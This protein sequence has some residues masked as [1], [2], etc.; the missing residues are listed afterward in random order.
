MR[1]LCIFILCTII[2]PSSIRSFNCVQRY[3]AQR[4]YAQRDCAQHYCAQRDCA[5]HFC[6]Q[7]DWAQCGCAQRDCAQHYCARSYCAQHYYVR[8]PL[9]IAGRT[10]IYLHSRCIYIHIFV[11]F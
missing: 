6:A 10:K 9:C 7:R 5:Q 3:R 4:Y 8:I 1:W 2:I 11:Q